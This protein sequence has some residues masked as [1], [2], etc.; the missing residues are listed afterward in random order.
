MKTRIALVCV[1]AGLLAGCTDSDWDRSLN[2]V[3]IGDGKPAPQRATPVR[4]AEAAPP[5]QMTRQAPA[6]LAPQAAPADPFCQSV[7]TQDAQSNGFDAATQRGVYQ[8][9]Y[10]QCVAMFAGGSR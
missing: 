3:G 1:A 2:F 5:A 10:N 6:Q 9:S 4:R 7:A 8:R